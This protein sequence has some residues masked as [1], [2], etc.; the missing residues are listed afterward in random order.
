M[1]GFPFSEFL[2]VH[3]APIEGYGLE[4]LGVASLGVGKV[5][6][7]VRCTAARASTASRLA[8]RYLR[9]KRSRSALASAAAR[10]IDKILSMAMR[11]T[12]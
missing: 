4:D 7:A 12:G 2:I 1:G 5:A 8:L 11:A 3:A 6:S 9:L 10:H